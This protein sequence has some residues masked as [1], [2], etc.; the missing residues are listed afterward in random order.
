MSSNCY[1][2]KVLA[3]ESR[4]SSNDA[5]EISPYKKV[6][7]MQEV[8]WWI[9]KFTFNMFPN[10]KPYETVSV[11]DKLFL[12]VSTSKIED[13]HSKLTLYINQNSSTECVLNQTYPRLETLTTGTSKLSMCSQQSLTNATNATNTPRILITS[14]HFKK[15]RFESQEIGLLRTSIENQTLICLGFCLDME[16]N[17]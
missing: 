7:V 13:P 12:R 3:I 1:L 2:V 8:G 4:E 16:T 17:I 6:E 15:I 14:A 10:Y 5:G 9:K 11:G